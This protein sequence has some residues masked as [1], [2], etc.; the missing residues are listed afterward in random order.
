LNQRESVYF[1]VLTEPCPYLQLAWR[2]LEQAGTVIW[3][4]AIFDLTVLLEYFNSLPRGGTVGNIDSLNN[5][6]VLG[7]SVLG[8]ILGKYSVPALLQQVATRSQDTSLM[9]QVQGLPVL[10]LQATNHSYT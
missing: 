4:N 3:H 10:S 2:L 5:S 7:G 9:A 1:R 6:R 8:G